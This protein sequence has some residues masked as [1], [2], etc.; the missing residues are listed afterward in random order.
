MAIFTISVIF[1][2]FYVCI[3]ELKM[4]LCIYNLQNLY[5]FSFKIFIRKYRMLRMTEWNFKIGMCTI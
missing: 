4:R 5:H 3:N 1:I 2:S